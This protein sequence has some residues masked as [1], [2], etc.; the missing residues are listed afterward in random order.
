[1]EITDS[2]KPGR[3]RAE[4]SEAVLRREERIRN[5]LLMRELLLRLEAERVGAS[6]RSGPETLYFHERK[7]RVLLRNP[8]FAAK[9]LLATRWRRRETSA[10][11]EGRAAEVRF[12][13]GVRAPTPDLPT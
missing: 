11:R 10:G 7:R 3:L 12:S 4:E 1:M 8:R 13:E 6:G 2:L 5:R 9:Y